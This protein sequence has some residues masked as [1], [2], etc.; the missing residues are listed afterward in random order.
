LSTLHNRGGSF[1]YGAGTWKQRCLGQKNPTK[2]RGQLGTE[3]ATGELF[4]MG[5]SKTAGEDSAKIRGGVQ[6]NDPQTAGKPETRWGLEGS[7]QANEKVKQAVREKKKGAHRQHT[8]RKTEKMDGTTT[9]TAGKKHK[10]SPHQENFQKKLVTAVKQWGGKQKSGRGHGPRLTQQ[11][12][13][14]KSQ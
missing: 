12:L 13:R 8:Q 7:V 9:L 4:H 3:A 6:K 10:K 5:G 11:E 1:F 2:P 14:P